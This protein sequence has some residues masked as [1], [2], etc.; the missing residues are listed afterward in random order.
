MLL[1]HVAVVEGDPSMHLSSICAAEGAAAPSSALI[2]IMLDF[3]CSNTKVSMH[4]GDMERYSKD[5][6]GLL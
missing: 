5:D 2:S 1:N 3:L 4:R 6:A